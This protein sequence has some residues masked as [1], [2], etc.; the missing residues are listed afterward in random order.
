MATI[1][2]K[3]GPS[4]CLPDTVG[5]R[6]CPGAGERGLEQGAGEQ[7]LDTPDVANLRHDVGSPGSIGASS[8]S[9]LPGLAAYGP[10]A[11]S[12]VRL[13]RR[14]RAVSA[15]VMAESDQSMASAA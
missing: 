5:V 12:S 15:G 1:E 3:Q 2:A 10:P 6:T 4:V 9:S 14:R 11:S 7:S 8:P 13:R